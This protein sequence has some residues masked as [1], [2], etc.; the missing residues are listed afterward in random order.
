MLKEKRWRRR[1]SRKPQKGC[2]HRH[3]DC[4]GLY[5]SFRSISFCKFISV[6][7]YSKKEMYQKSNNH[8]AY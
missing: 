4:G 1:K 6:F 8:G 2:C 3:E 5:N 7:L